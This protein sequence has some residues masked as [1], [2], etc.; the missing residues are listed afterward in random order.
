MK[1]SVIFIILLIIAIPVSSA[2]EVSILEMFEIENQVDSNSSGKEVYFYAGSKLIAVNDEYQYQ[3]RLGS[4][5]ESKSLPFGQSVNEENRF[6]FTGKELDSELYYFNARYYDPTLGKFTS[7]DPVPTEP[8]YAYV[9]NNPLNLIDLTGTSVSFPETG[10]IT[11]EF[12]GELNKLFD[13]ENPVFSLRGSYMTISQEK[14]NFNSLEQE[15]VYRVLSFLVNSNY[16]TFVKYIEGKGYA[17]DHTIYF[18]PSDTHVI[19]MGE[20]GR[21]TKLNPVITFV[22]EAIH[23]FGYKEEDAMKYGNYVRQI[24]AEMGE[25][26][27]SLGVPRVY[28][29]GRLDPGYPSR[30]WLYTPET[31][32]EKYAHYFFDIAIQDAINVD[33]FNSEFGDIFDFPIKD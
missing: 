27:E 15:K 31:Y 8:A 29:G 4:D 5:F 7:V 1:N 21:D 30:I 9:Y 10:E 14:I 24:Y 6:S 18:N 11:N 28:Y 20:G 33:A 26:Y 3:D 25:D 23:T 32:D 13:T 16:E 17:S 22:H 19:S 12:I 2:K